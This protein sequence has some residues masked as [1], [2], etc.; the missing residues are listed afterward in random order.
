M[1]EMLGTNLPLLM[2]L[3]PYPLTANMIIPQ[4]HQTFMKT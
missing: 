2:A 4:G 1:K 3:T